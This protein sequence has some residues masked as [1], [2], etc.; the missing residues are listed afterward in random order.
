MALNITNTNYSGE[1]LERLLTLAATGNQIVEKGL[2]HVEP[3]IQY[4]LSIPR[5]KRSTMLQKR[6]AMPAASDSKGNF[7]YSERTLTPKDFMAF[8]TF[9]PRT[10]ER[11]WR[12]WQPKGQLVFSQLPPEAQNALLDELSKQVKFELG[13]HYINGVYAES[14]DDKLFDG[15]VT[16]MSSDTDKISVET[17]A[18]TIIGRLNALYKAIPDELID[19]KNFVIIMSTADH[20][21]YGEELI[22]KTYK[23]IDYNQATPD[24]FRGVRIE[25]LSQWPT[26]L[27][28]G[29]I[30]SPDMDSNLWAAVNLAEDEDVI[31]I[32][33]LENAGELYFF[34]M[35]MKADTQVAFGEEIVWLDKRTS[36][37]APIVGEDEG[38][39]E[40]H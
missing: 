2:L 6:K 12:K 7:S 5:L 24:N 20:R 9:N 26:S 16:R 15:I 25:T 33:K 27:F 31:Q 1:V 37:S 22:S 30:A 10:F 38:E 3:Q 34:K 29:T 18:D 11:V 23:G 13:G 39:G 8:T 36:A 21:A 28:V 40:Q 14:G 35:L 32:D 17:T 19:N 4:A